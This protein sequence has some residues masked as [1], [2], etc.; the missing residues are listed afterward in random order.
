[1]P[2]DYFAPGVYVEEVDRGSRPIEGITMSVA[3]F[4]G[5]TEDVRGGAEL[6]KPMLITSWSQYQ[7]YFA[8]QGSDGFTDFDAYLP[9]SVYGWFLNGGGRCWITS[10]G[11]QLPGVK[12]VESVA[13]AIIQTAG[14]RPS[15]AL[16]LKAAATS[17]KAQKAIA[18][19]SS[20][21]EISV[22][23][24]EETEDQRVKVEIIPSGPRPISGESGAEAPIDTGEFFSVSVTRGGDVLE[25]YDYLSMNPNAKLTLARC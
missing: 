19:R 1:M 9:F 22:G 14:K 17:A 12:P 20:A 7:E 15:L 10:L 16:K 6:F 23:G 21:S 18:A 13:K 2:L 3:G 8:K 24:L 11:T 5:F 25:T 4:V